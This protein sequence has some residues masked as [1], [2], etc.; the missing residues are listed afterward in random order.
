MTQVSNVYQAFA[1]GFFAMYITGPWNVTP[2]GNNLPASLKNTWMTAPL[3]AY[4]GNKYPGKSF[5][6]GSSLVMFKASKHKKEAWKLMN[7][8][9]RNLPRWNFLSFPPIYLL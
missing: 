9:L 8:F 1:C 7:F 3:P 2:F 6:G 5:A 4:D